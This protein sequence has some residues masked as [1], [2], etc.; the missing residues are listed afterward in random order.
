[1]QARTWSVFLA[2]RVSPNNNVVTHQTRPQDLLSALPL[3]VIALRM[4]LNYSRRITSLTVP[5][6]DLKQSE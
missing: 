6:S 5:K 1:M 2:A 4:C 3:A